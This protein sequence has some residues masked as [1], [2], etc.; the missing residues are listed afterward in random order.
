ERHACGDS[1]GAAD[2]DRGVPITLSHPESASAKALR[3]VANTVAAKVA[4]AALA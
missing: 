3:E 4:N 1:R 2:G